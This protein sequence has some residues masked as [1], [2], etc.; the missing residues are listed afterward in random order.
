MGAP[1]EDGGAGA[2]YIYRGSAD[3]LVTTVSQRLS[4][5]N[6]GL[7]LK[8]FGISLSRGA[9]VDKNGYTGTQITPLSMCSEMNE[10]GKFVT[11]N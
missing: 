6:V 10:I 4:A 5:R 3:G 9:D 2:V 8:G 11:N 1:Y 7:N